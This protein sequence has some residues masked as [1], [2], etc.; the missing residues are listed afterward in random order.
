MKFNWEL[1]QRKQKMR[2]QEARIDFSFKREE[3]CSG[4]YRSQDSC[5]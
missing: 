2:G 4:E 1:R 5:K 3:G